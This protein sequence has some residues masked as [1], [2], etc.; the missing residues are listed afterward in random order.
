MRGMFGRSAQRLFACF[1]RTFYDLVRSLCQTQG[2]LTG[3]LRD[4]N[5]HTHTHTHRGGETE[6]EDR[7]TCRP[8]G[9]QTYRQAHRK[10]KQISHSIENY[11]Q[12]TFDWT[13]YCQRSVLRSGPFFPYP[14]CVCLAIINCSLIGKIH[15]LLR[16]L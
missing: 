5:R 6:H 9:R 15:R 10:L 11:L 4:T 8:R 16:L 14:N 2:W 12:L 1:S 3:T 13:L 7:Q